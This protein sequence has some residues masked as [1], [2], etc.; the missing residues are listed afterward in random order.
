MDVE[1]ELSPTASA[2]DG[3]RE[4]PAMGAERLHVVIGT[5]QVG[6]T[7]LAHLARLGVAVRA[8]SRGRPRVAA[9]RRLEGR[10]RHRPRSRDRYRQRAHRWSTSV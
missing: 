8:V 5:G 1:A 3:K 4:G 10:G 2:L 7:L 6:S 9:R